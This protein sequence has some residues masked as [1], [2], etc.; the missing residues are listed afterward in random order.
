LSG[1]LQRAFA[2][3]SFSFSFFTFISHFLVIIICTGFGIPRSL[4]SSN[5]TRKNNSQKKTLA[6]RETQI[7]RRREAQIDWRRN[8]G[9]KN[10][11]NK[12]STANC[13]E[14]RQLDPAS[15]AAYAITT[16]KALPS[17]LSNFLSYRFCLA[18]VATSSTQL[19][20]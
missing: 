2:D 15:F 13:G 6:S 1:S 20:A 7:D 12:T 18:D 14:L 9:K 17:F 5:L 10:D 3:L 16:E 11:K 8:G 4:P 19:V